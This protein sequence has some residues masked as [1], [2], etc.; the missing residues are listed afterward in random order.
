ARGTRRSQ[1]RLE[2]PRASPRPDAPFLG[3]TS[4]PDPL[5]TERH[6]V[7]VAVGS[8][9]RN[10]SP[11]VLPPSPRAGRETAERWCV[12]RRQWGPLRRGDIPRVGFRCQTGLH[13]PL[14]VGQRPLLNLPIRPSFRTQ[15]GSDRIV[16]AVVAA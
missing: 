9:E 15:I 5:G 14:L 3:R 12:Y 6:G 16:C 11:E 4:A 7:C 10:T 13:Q 1:T 8:Y 2:S